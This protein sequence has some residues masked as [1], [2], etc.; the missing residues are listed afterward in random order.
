MDDATRRWLLDQLGTNTDL[1][2]LD[3]RYAL[4]GT[5]RAVAISILTQRHTDLVTNQPASA[6]VSGVI[7]FAYTENIKAIERKLALLSAADAP[8]APDEPGYDGDNDAGT[9]SIVQLVER[10]RR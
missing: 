1:V 2:D 3:A 8:P 4:L 7:G 5:A 10:P 6:N 9:W